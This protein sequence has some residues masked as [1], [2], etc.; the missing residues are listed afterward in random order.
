MLKPI[1]TCENTA[2]AYQL[3]WGITLNWA[4]PVEESIW[5]DSVSSLLESDHIRILSWR[6]LT[7]VSIQFVISTQ[8]NIKPVFIIQRLK[9]RIQYAVRE[10]VPKA[11]R[12]NY[13]LRSFG[14]QE[15]QIVEGYIAAQ[16]SHHAMPTEKSQQIFEDLRFVD[17]KVD[18]SVMQ[19]TT[20]GVYWYNLH[21]VIV[22]SERWRDINEDRLQRVKRVVLRCG[23]QKHCRISRLSILA[24][25]LH[26][27]IGC[28]IDDSPSAVVLSMMNNIA[29]VYGM[30]PVLQYSAFIATFGEYDHRAIE[31]NGFDS[32]RR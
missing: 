6:W 13:A 14:T 22:N 7:K 32:D 18:L 1:Y 28:P 12:S 24:D 11:F 9:G 16:P 21:M 20:H 3:R 30:K 29:W 10:K 31:S 19:K 5:L 17:E 2:F 8:P 27:A 15:R 25:H 4:T 26:L 23:V